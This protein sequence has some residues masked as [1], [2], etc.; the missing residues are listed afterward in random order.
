MS[1]RPDS[2][3]PGHV[4]ING[5]DALHSHAFP[6]AVPLTVV[7]QHVPSYGVQRYVVADASGRRGHAY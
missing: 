2:Y 4:F 6:W 5:V 3:R 1:I 7:H